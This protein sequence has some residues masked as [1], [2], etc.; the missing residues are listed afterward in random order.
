MAVC[1]YCHE[2]RPAGELFTPYGTVQRCRDTEACSRRQLRAFD[3]S[4]APDE[5][6]PVA[7]CSSAP[8]GLACDVCH[9]VAPGGGLY[10]RALG[11]WRCR[12]RAGCEQRQRTPDLAPVTE[13]FPE[14]GRANFTGMLAAQ[15]AAGAQNPGEPAPVDHAE[16]AALAR[17]DALGRK[18]QR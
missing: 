9:A 8:A 16:T 1:G 4:I 2:A 5:D 10:E 13:D 12:D 6:L 11:M 17:V 15:A 3:P 7:P 14:V 18:R